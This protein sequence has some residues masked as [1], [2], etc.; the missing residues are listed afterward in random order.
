MN[1]FLKNLFFVR[2]CVLCDRALPD[3]EADTVFCEDCER[4]Y[5]KLCREVCP[6][7]EKTERECRCVPR[8]LR[9]GVGFSAHLF[10]FYDEISR[11]IVYAF[12]MKNYP[13]LQRFL[14][15]ELSDLI[16]DVT[17]GDLSGFTVT[18]APRKPRSI[19]IYGFD[20]SKILA[21]LVSQRLGL[22]FAEI[23][24]HSRFSKLQKNLHTKER[25]ENAEK[26]YFLREDFVRRTDKLLIIDDVMTTGSTLSALV[27]LSKAIGFREVSVICIA[28]TGRA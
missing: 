10:S 22:P 1:N 24:C 19:R 15:G 18:F 21:L 6:S 14:A 17:G 3:A 2:K 23:F 12:K 5:R 4:E 13:H 25:L 27:A 11:R 7:C 9:G 20:Q 8:R 16:L 26:S 28:K